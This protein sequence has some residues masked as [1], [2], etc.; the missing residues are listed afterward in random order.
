MTKPAP[1]PHE[2]THTLYRRGPRGQGSP[3]LP[4]AKRCNQCRALLEL[5]RP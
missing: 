1:C 5:P 3:F 4:D 2:K